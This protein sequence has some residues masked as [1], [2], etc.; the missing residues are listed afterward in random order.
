MTIVTKNIILDLAKHMV[1]S[2]SAMYHFKKKT[3]Q[4]L[5]IFLIKYC[6]VLAF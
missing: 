5:F 4:F 2:Q 1:A 6:H 3:K